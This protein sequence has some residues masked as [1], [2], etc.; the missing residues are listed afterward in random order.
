MVLVIIVFPK[1]QQYLSYCAAGS[2]PFTNILSQ[3]S[4]SETI[5]TPATIC[6]GLLGLPLLL[7]MDFPV[8]TSWQVTQLQNP[9]LKIHSFDPS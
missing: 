5:T 1:S 3:F 9:I 2:F 4:T 6:F 8:S 7:V